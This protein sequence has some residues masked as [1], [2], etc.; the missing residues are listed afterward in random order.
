MNRCLYQMVHYATTSIV[1]MASLTAARRGKHVDPRESLLDRVID[2]V[3]T[4]GLADQSLRELAAGAG[5]SHRMLLYHFGSHAGLIAAIAA[6]VEAQQRD[7]LARMANEAGSPA[8]LQRRLWAQVSDPTLAPFVRLFFDVLGL[9]L[10]RRPGTEDFTAH[11]VEPWL[12]EAQTAAETVGIQS[13]R[14]DLRLGVAVT[15]GLLI[16]LLATGDVEGTTA[17]HERFIVLWQATWEDPDP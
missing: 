15:R 9:A 14:E 11:L 5:T 8:D 13:R 7:L 17:A 12:A 10:A 3:A 1:T 2:H 16:D 4:T 6:R